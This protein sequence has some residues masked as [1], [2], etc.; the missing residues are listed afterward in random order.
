MIIFSS[1]SRI[2]NKRTNGVKT[3]SVAEAKTAKSIITKIIKMTLA[4]Q[5]SM[6][7]TIP[8]LGQMILIR[9][10]YLIEIGA[11]GRMEWLNLHLNYLNVIPM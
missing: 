7:T 6:I 4:P 11:E 3:E 8:A 9:C 1:Y 5:T 10:L 2:E